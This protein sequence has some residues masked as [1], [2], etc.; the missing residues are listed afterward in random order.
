MLQVARVFNL[1]LDSTP[2]AF[3]RSSATMGNN[4]RQKLCLICV[5]PKGAGGC[6][7]G[8]GPVDADGMGLGNFRTKGL[9]EFLLLHRV[10][11]DALVRASSKIFE[12]QKGRARFQPGAL[13]RVGVAL[14]DL[15]GTSIATSLHLR[16]RRLQMTSLRNSRRD[17][18]C[19]CGCKQLRND[20]SNRR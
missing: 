12:M 8:G 13:I 3:A 19:R 18:R 5:W 14:P 17:F 6:A 1:L 4:E 7:F 2:Q 20:P 10:R 11:L 9:S 16:H 15:P